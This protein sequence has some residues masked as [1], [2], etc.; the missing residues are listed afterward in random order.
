MVSL[1]KLALLGIGAAAALSCSGASVPLSAQKGSTIL[2]PIGGIADE[3]AGTIGFG[4]QVYEDRQRGA[5]VFKLGGPTGPELVTRVVTALSGP[6][7]SQHG[8]ASPFGFN[9]DLIVAMIDIPDT[10]AITEGSHGLTI[11]R[12]LGG[13]DHPGPVYDGQISILPAMVPAG[14][15]TIVGTPT[16]FEAI[17]VDISTVV[18]NAVPDPQAIF[19][20]TGAPAVHAVEM[21]ITFPTSLVTIRDVTEAVLSGGSGYYDG[22]SESHRAHAWW[23]TLSAGRIAVGMLSP[24]RPLRGLSVVFA[25]KAAATE[26]VA[27]SVF[28]ISNVRAYGVNGDAVSPSWGAPWIR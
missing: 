16:P 12:R 17:G 28:A 5:L 14:T 25:L 19:A 8:I 27:P 3:D 24:D 1:S 23:K 15:Q 26:P 4:S 7:A 10:P 13:V 9:T 18:R 21:E 6:L 2:I 22:V 20:V 11:V